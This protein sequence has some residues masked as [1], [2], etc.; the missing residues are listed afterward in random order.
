MTDK[1]NP[2]H[3]EYRRGGVTAVDI[4]ETFNFNLGNAVK[5]IWRAGLKEGETADDDLKKA[6]W[7]L[8]RELDRLA[9]DKR[10]ESWDGSR[11]A[12]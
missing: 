10:D 11:H 1:I 12:T 5:Y 9:W 4:T 8:E 2:E 3:Y 6:V 7:Y